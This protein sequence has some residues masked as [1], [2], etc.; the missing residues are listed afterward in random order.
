MKHREL[1]GKKFTPTFRDCPQ[2][3]DLLNLEDM[4]LQNFQTHRPSSS[5]NTEFNNTLVRKRKK[6][7]PETEQHE[8]KS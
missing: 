2:H 6:P 8:K 1:K 7:H 4:P 5:V 3:K